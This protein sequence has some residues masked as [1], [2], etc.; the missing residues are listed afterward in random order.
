MRCEASPFPRRYDVSPGPMRFM[1]GGLNPQLHANLL[2]T[3]AV[4]REQCA[5]D[6][7]F[8]M[9]GDGDDWLQRA[10]TE[11]LQHSVEDGCAEGVEEAPQSVSKFLLK[12]QGEE[13]TTY[14][15]FIALHNRL[16]DW[17]CEPGSPARPSRSEAL[18]KF[19]ERSSRRSST[20]SSAPAFQRGDSYGSR[21]LSAGRRP[22]VEG[23]ISEHDNDNIA[24]RSHTETFIE[25]D[26]T[27][28]RDRRVQMGGA[29]ERE[30]TRELE[31]APK[32]SDD[33]AA[34]AHVG[35]V[36]ATWAA[37]RGNAVC[38]CVC[39][40]QHPSGKA[41]P[42]T[43]QPSSPARCGRA[44]PTQRE[45]ARSGLAAPVL[46]LPKRSARAPACCRRPSTSRTHVGA[47]CVMAADSPSR[48]CVGV[49]TPL[50]S[51]PLAA[52]TVL[53][54]CWVP[55][56]TAADR[57]RP[58]RRRRRRGRRRASSQGDALAPVRDAERVSGA[59]PGPRG[60]L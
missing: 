56:A 30:A 10:L 1:S 57:G 40:A 4:E 14:D 2:S 35:T 59:D 50:S 7:F 28:A 11:V 47:P 45:A 29:R 27:P 44:A 19:E 36:C 12:T 22:T 23:R 20:R 43:R 13:P 37:T 16:L 48:A 32:C 31:R 55:C 18:R 53:H 38:V 51:W 46:T 41:R 8:L 17:F 26:M 21:R 6:V 54:A 60:G 49:L 33:G 52:D 25:R 3:A 58:H 42:A 39:P 34:H 15:E 9:C 5:C 24:R